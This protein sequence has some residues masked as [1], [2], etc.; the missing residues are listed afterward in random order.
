MA[1]V[2]QDAQTRYSGR[3]YEGTCRKALFLRLAGGG[4][5]PDFGPDPQEALAADFP[6]IGLAIALFEQLAE[7]IRIAGDVLK[8]LRDL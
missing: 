8:A 6:D 4:G 2:A 3:A 7:E 5:L 1:P